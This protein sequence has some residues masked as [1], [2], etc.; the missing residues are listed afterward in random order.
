MPTFNKIR[1]I[2]HHE[3]PDFFISSIKKI[4]EGDNSKAFLINQNYIFRFPKRKEVKQQ[5][6]KE[7]SVLPII[8]SL[9]DLKIPAF[10]FISKDTNFVGHKSINGVFL[11]TEIY[12]SLEKKIQTKIQKALGVFLTQLHQINLSILKDYELDM[13]DYQ[14]E[15]SHN[16]ED[17]QQLIYPN[18]SVRDSKIITL[19]FTAYLNDPKN[20]E[21]K[22]ALIH[23]DFSTDHILFETSNNVISGI[24]DFG[25]LAIGDPDYD[26]I[27]L[28][29]SFGKDFILKVLK[30][31]KHNDPKNLLKK[32]QFFTLG[33]KLQM[34]IGSIKDKDE[35][36][37][38]DG[39]GNLKKW[40]KKYRMAEHSCLEII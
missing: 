37:I 22:P 10:D 13:M 11:T 20:F 8:Q 2:I 24:I 36:G 3:F 5:L 30:F 17:T 21:Y 14:E 27:Y 6:K 16:F 15:Y 25:D 12:K 7:T 9:L 28:L 32:L 38:K 23:N 33:S 29:D 40:F 35:S 4:G 31:Y 26:L 19:F 39:Y 1:E 34:L 18:I